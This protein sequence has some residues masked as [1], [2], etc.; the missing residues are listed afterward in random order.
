MK[1]HEIVKDAE[2]KNLLL[3]QDLEVKPGKFAEAIESSYNIWISII[4]S[5]EYLY[6]SESLEAFDSV[7]EENAK[8]IAK[9]FDGDITA[10]EAAA[11]SNAIWIG[12]INS[13]R[14]P[15]VPIINLK[16]YNTN[17]FELYNNN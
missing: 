14:N 1:I 9:L 10:P 2:R 7:I 6:Q 16:K 8:I 15:G 13:I 11:Q 17:T 4:K 3:M 5:N 12:K